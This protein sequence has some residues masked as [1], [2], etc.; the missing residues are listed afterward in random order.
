MN[1]RNEPTHKI[2]GRVI[3]ETSKHGINGLRV[4]GWDKDLHHDDLI[5]SAITDAEGR[6]RIEFTG[7]YFRELF[8]DREPDLFFKVFSDDKLIKSTEDSV[9]WNVHDGATM[10]EIVVPWNSTPATSVKE[11]VYTVTGTVSSPD[12]AGL[13]GLRVEI[14]DKNVGRDDSLV[15]TIT[16]ERGQYSLTFNIKS[17]GRKK[18]PD[19]QARVYSHQTFL[20]ASAV[21]YNATTQETLNVTLPANSSALPS[22]HETLT[23]TL[24]AHFD[25]KLRD[26][27]ETD[28]QQDITYLA[29][30]IGW[31]ARAVALASLADQFSQLSKDAAGAPTIEPAFYYALFRAGLPA[32]ADV[33]YQADGNTVERILKQAIEQGVISKAL[34]EKIGKSVEAFQRL[35][36]EKVL[37]APAIVGASSLKEMLVASRLEDAEQQQFAQ[38]YTTHRT[39][40]P[41]FWNE[42][43][44]TLGAEKAN[45]LQLNG[46]LG[47]LTIN[48]ASLIS[49]LHKTAADGGISDLVTLAHSGFYRASQ[50]NQVLTDSIPVPS[51]IPGETAETK[52]ANYAAY[53]AA[54]VRLSY[55]TASV[56]QMVSNGELTVN[57]PG[58]V[59]K[60]LTDHEGQFEIGMQPVQRFIAQNQLEVAPE[61]VNELQR[62]QRVYQI[63]PSDEALTGLMKRRI[64][65]AFQVAQFEKETFVKSFS[66]DLGGVADASLTYDKA[67]Q[68]HSTVLNIALSYITAR[69]GIG[70]GASRLAP[71]QS[72]GKGQI[73]Q[74]SPG[75]SA[76]AERS[77]TGVERDEAD[78]AGDILAYATLET[79]F[80]EMDFCACDHCRSILSPAA[81]L[82]DLLMFLDHPRDPDDSGKR[83]P[84]D[85]LLERR[86][87]IKDLPLT[88]ENT[89]TALPYIDIIN[90]TLEYYITNE[91]P[92]SLA[93]YA[94]HDTGQAASEDLLAT[95][96]SF[97]DGV[98]DAAYEVLSNEYFP[99]PLPFHQRLEN[100]RRYFSKF[101]V[102]LPLAMERLR[103]ND[104]FEIDRNASPRP[105]LTDYAWV[106]ILMEEL[107]L[108]RAEYEILTNSDTVQLWRM[109][110]FPADA[111]VIDKLSHA[112]QYARRLNITYEDI[113]AIL[114]TRFVNPNSDL[115]PKLQRLGVA[116]AALKQLRDT[117]TP[118]GDAAFDA[119]LPT[120]AGAPDPHEYDGNIKAWVKRP[121]NFDRIMHIITLT[122]IPDPEDP[123]G[124]ADPCNFD[125]VE[126]RFSQPM[127]G[128]EDQ[129]TRLQAAEFVRLLRFVRL[130]KK[131]GWTIEQT[132][133]AICALF[134]VP[135]LP[136]PA[137]LNTLAELD[138]GFRTLLPRLGIVLRVMK[139][140]NLTP[141]R[142]LLS[143]LAL[144]SPLGTHGEHA[145]YRQMFLNP[146]LAPL[147]TAFADN[148]Y[149]SFLQNTGEKVLGHIET[150]R[151]AFGLTSDEFSQILIALGFTASVD[152]P[153]TLDNISAIYRRGWLAR[154]LKISVKELLLLIEQTGLDPFA[155]PDSTNPAIMRTIG[156]VESLKARS[157]KIST[158]LYMVWN[159]DLSG[160]SAPSQAQLTTFA[161]T[162]RG[163][164]AQTESDFSIADDPA[165]EIARARMEL[166]YGRQATEFF[167]GLLNETFTLSAPYA[168]FQQRFGP[169]F[170]S[171]IQTTAGHFGSPAVSRLT[172]D[173]FRKQ[174]TF[175]GVLG[176]SQREAIKL[177]VLAP[178]VVAEVSALTP[179]ELAAFQSSFRLAVDA[180]YSANNAAVGPFFA[181]YEEL[182][183]FYTTF[184]NSTD[185]VETKRRVLLENFI[186]SFIKR[187]KEQQALQSVGDEAQTTRAFA[188]QLL[189]PSPVNSGLHA[190]NQTATPALSDL[191]ALETLGLS[192]DFYDGDAVGANAHQPAIAA[193]LS[194][195]AT[196]ANTLPPNVTTPG[197]AISGRWTG[198]IE[199][200]EN[201]LYNLIIEAELGTT[202]TLTFD[203]NSARL[204]QTGSVWRNAAPLALAGG[205]LYEV[206]LKA[207]RILNTFRVEWETAGRGREVI[208]A[209]SLYPATIFAAARD[210]YL[211]FIKSAALANALGLTAAETA[212]PQLSGATWLNALPV[213]GNATTPANLLDPLTDLLTYARIKADLSPGDDRLFTV[214][215]DPVRSMPVVERAPG[216]LPTLTHWDSVSLD[217]ILVHTGN[218]LEDLS[219]I[220]QF[221]RVYEVFKLSQKVGMSVSALID[222]VTNEP[223]RDTVRNLQAALRARFDPANWR[224]VV[225]PIND[226]MRSLQRDALVAYILHKLS[227]DLDSA[228]IDT[229]DKLFEYFLMDVE[230]APCMQTSRIRHALSSVQLF[231]ERCLMNLEPRVSPSDINAQQWQW[232][233]RYRVWEAN[234]KVFLFPENW[235]EPELRDDKS[236]FFKEIESQLLQSDV[237]EESATS[238]LLTYLSRLEEVAKLEPCGIYHDEGDDRTGPIEHVIARTAGAHRK[239]YY[240]RYEFGFWTPWE[241]VKLEIDDNPVVP[242]VWKSEEGQ[243]LL[244]F[245]LKILKKGPSSTD[246][247]KP[248][249]SNLDDMKVPTNPAM[250]TAQA[251]LCWSE[252][253]NGKWQAVKT[254]DMN[255][256]TEL[257]TF[258]GDTFDRS[259]V[260]LNVNENDLGLSIG[261]TGQGNSS[262]L[263][264]NTHSLP[265]RKE[266]VGLLLALI[267]GLPFRQFSTD[268]NRLSITYSVLPLP[269]SPFVNLPRTVLTTTTR[270]PGRITEPRHD[271]PDVWNAPFFYEDGRHVFYVTTTQQQVL[272]RD[273]KDFGIVTNPLFSDITSIPHLIV[274]SPE[275]IPG[276]IGP[277]P[278]FIG[279]PTARRFVTEDAQI[280][281]IL[282][283]A[284]VVQ[285]DGREIGP[286]GALA[287]ITNK[288]E[289]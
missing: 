218:R 94:G 183:S 252:Y 162:L 276:P 227:S 263:M 45:R 192:V 134:P 240:R 259:K 44:K 47:F 116:F 79:L 71:E 256:P 188:E 56:A 201:G 287:I 68:I 148:G 233:K 40:L 29:N 74:P 122:P 117:D 46:K 254:S 207:E 210:A 4:E 14:V 113:A 63:T 95:P 159:Q 17:D 277:D 222:S 241:Q 137:P 216:L 36:V 191:L 53:L 9:L 258:R 250:V 129:S 205:T 193:N 161:R 114:K 267:L 284:D 12:R 21:R 142:D 172:Y 89:N 239:Y 88:C 8:L 199:A 58:E 190:A 156:L 245:W 107:G 92:L 149:G 181:H 121:D 140:L 86:P 33:L 80:G 272:V 163:N 126:F 28:E 105:P 97:T 248:E 128:I 52:R 102:A 31:D 118:V 194:Y 246:G 51:E 196:T 110:G 266:E 235:L 18:A 70:L 54:Q 77:A 171:A 182:R 93:G 157:I 243:R 109:Y 177:T 38:L 232:M 136:A 34:D 141:A 164:L 242:Y 154:K 275:P 212:R 186:P 13:G 197:N 24:A 73:L 42:V 69:N 22:E 225:Q 123:V 146:T 288:L 175:T 83:N 37:T 261:I 282:G 257:G 244:L 262:F 27:K 82:V 11:T 32:N 255:L 133:A 106:D 269:P 237:T 119:L 90:E 206:E 251:V 219:S 30:K 176:E 112:K 209:R 236:P 130:W 285:F 281:R 84:Q 10:I 264:H 127:A 60:F 247:Q 155:P 99:A 283:T 230:M 85:V 132:D 6:F 16:D 286:S 279:V 168:H 169:V 3:S 15:E 139:A 289:G 103:K 65:S 260:L 229:P 211:R 96:Q 124:S 224:T 125:H 145:L 101:D 59:H 39:D 23:G 265:E 35:S 19:L 76:L 234:R 178:A 200:P 2:V 273:S 61:I 87:D 238:A 151:A 208:P 111:D 5:G 143:C 57:A 147:D 25:G 64:D 231:I 174:L 180:L 104:D 153:L 120:G 214:M 167:F 165:G 189:N 72:D 81:Y 55:P 187:R 48:N 98:R 226:E 49:E 217:K 131:L 271:L 195:A 268:G 280:N 152:P 204:I 41:K 150:L 78:N 7:A 184:I 75:R 185:P 91:T 135:T 20:A 108:S 66:H 43:E 160:K 221:S 228:H 220:D 67:V 270:P 144:W 50:W 100:L 173:D 158:A 198:Y 278:A 202:V 253:Y 203:G 62:V 138:T 274:D 26:L 249:G 223:T 213:I 1:Y 215:N 179:T 115:I 170:A 166:V